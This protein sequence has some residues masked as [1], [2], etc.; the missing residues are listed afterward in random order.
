MKTINTIKLH[1]AAAIFCAAIL[2]LTTT[3]NAGPQRLSGKEIEPVPVAPEFSWTGLYIGGNIGG[4][5]THYDFS[6]FELTVD[7]NAMD[8]EQDEFDDATEEDFPDAGFEF[9]STTDGKVNLGSDNSVMGGGQVG[10]Q[11]QWHHLVIGVEGDWDRTSA[12]RSETFSSSSVAPADSVDAPNDESATT[13]I[14]A[15]R[16][17]QTEWMAS[18]RGRLGWAQGPV[19]LYATGGAAFAQVNV[20]AND[21]ATTATFIQDPGSTA[22]GIIQAGS[23]TETNISRVDKIQMGWTAGGG[24]EWTM[25]DAVSVGLEYR[26]SDFGRETYHFSS[27]GNAI[28]PDPMRVSLE[29]DQVAFK[30]NVLLCNFFH[31][32]H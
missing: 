11:W 8:A 22:P 20:W 3:A 12:S 29:S 13:D 30:V 19:L 16:Q 17:A 4:V 21:T 1:L 27:H 10:F 14:T 32:R 25:N 23:Q 2:A 24:V 9:P 6:Q 5:W 31:M 7:V 15:T 28:I 26:H 18:A